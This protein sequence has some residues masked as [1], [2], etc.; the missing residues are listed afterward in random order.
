M[1]DYGCM[2]R[3]YRRNV[4]EAVLSCH[5]RSTFIPVL[6]NSFATKTTEVNVKHS[7]R[8]AGNSKYDLWKLI[9]LQFDLLTSMTSFPLRLLSIIGGLMATCGLLAGLV[10]GVMRIVYGPDWAVDGV[11]TVLA[12][13]FVFAGVQLFGLGLLGEYLS[14]VYVDVR[15]R[16]RYFIQEVLP[17]RS[18][19][20][21]HDEYSVVKFRDS[22]EGKA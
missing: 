18:A 14:R 11:L 5:E 22:G 16:P 10:I 1:N 12:V 8:F 15:G 3:A 6:A 7:E 20:S 13:L 9:N 4:V 17:N 2:L 21:P 19:H